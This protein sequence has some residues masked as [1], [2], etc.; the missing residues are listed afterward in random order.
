MI[1]RAQAAM[2]SSLAVVLFLGLVK[3][4]ASISLST[5]KAEY[6]VAVSCCTQVIWMKHTLQDSK[7]EYVNPISIFCDNTSAISILKNPILH[8]RTKQI[9]I[10][11][12][13][14]REQVTNQVVKLE[15]VTSIEQVADI[16]TKPLM[17][18]TFEHLR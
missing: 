14:L 3:N 15:Y 9:P 17:K 13:F 12:H 2:L 11:Y 4:R 7:I 8:S 10:K 6:I 16:F 1:G 5:A 18:E